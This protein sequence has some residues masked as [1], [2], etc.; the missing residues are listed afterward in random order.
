[1]HVETSS[2]VIWRLTAYALP[3]CGAVLMGIGALELAG[4]SHQ[5]TT[6]RALTYL[7]G[8]GLMML[9]LWLRTGVVIDIDGDARTVTV[10][11]R[12]AYLPR[13]RT[14]VG[15]DH[16][17]AIRV[18]RTPGWIAAIATCEDRPP[19]PLTVLL[20]RT[21]AGEARLHELLERIRALTGHPLPLA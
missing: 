1:M 18:V 19:V 3:A 6:A 4:V 14:V 20:P 9:F 11:V 8:G 17:R 16:L 7:L 21:A 10:A 13:T 5:L 2:H 15:F 12:R